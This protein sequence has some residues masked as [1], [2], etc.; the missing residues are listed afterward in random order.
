V[1]TFG[2]TRG[3]L[4]WALTL[5]EAGKV[6]THTEVYQLQDAGRALEDL[7]AGRVLGRAVLVP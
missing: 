1:H 7:E 2:G 3:D 4:E 6:S 5:A